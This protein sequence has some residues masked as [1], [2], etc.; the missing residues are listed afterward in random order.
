MGKETSKSIKYS[1][2][3]NIFLIVFGW[4]I[5]FIWA[6]SRFLFAVELTTP[7]LLIILWSLVSWVSIA[8][9]FISLFFYSWVNM[10][11]LDKKPLIN[12]I[13]LI[14]LYFSTTGVL[15]YQYHINTKVFLKIHN[16]SEKD[17]SITLKNSEETWDLGNFKSQKTNIVN[18]SPKFTSHDGRHYPKFEDLK[19]I[20][21][22]TN[23]K[24]TFEIPVIYPGNCAELSIDKECKLKQPITHK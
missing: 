17:I 4:L 3:I 24:D 21:S 19:F 23:K 22:S 15:S 1:N 11:N 13:I 8:I 16:N 2:Y 10:R 9:S 7:E 5:V 20:V 12:L 18:Y 6:W 14:G